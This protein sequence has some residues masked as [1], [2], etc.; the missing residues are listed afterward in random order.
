MPVAS[1]RARAEQNLTKLLADVAQDKSRRSR[2]AGGGRHDD[3]HAVA[4]RE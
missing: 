4:T 3:E 2:F 1:A